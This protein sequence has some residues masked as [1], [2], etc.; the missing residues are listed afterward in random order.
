MTNQNQKKPDI[1]SSGT[2]EGD[3]EGEEKTQK[4]G[5]TMSQEGVF[6]L[7]LFTGNQKNNLPA[8]LATLTP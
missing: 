2:M 6:G 5:E 4:D 3:R 1:A 8:S 7:K